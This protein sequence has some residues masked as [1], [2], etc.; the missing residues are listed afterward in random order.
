MIIE[1]MNSQKLSLKNLDIIT[2]KAED[3]AMFLNQ[4][5]EI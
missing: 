5:S 1:Y 2:L 3:V 4:A